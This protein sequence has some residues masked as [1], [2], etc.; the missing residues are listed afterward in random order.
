MPGKHLYH[1]GTYLGAGVKNSS[2]TGNG[3]INF[4]MC[5]KKKSHWSLDTEPR[6]GEKKNAFQ[7]LGVLGLRLRPIWDKK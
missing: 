6:V 2:G 1:L 5:V 7:D 3:G 4:G